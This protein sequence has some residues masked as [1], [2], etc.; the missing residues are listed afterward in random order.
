MSKIGIMILGHGSSYEY[1]K[2]IMY[3]Q[4]ER[5]EEMGFENVYIGFNQMTRPYIEDSMKAMAEDGIDEVVAV[6][7]FIASGLHMTHD[8]PPKLL[9]KEGENHVKVSVG[10]HEMLMHFEEPF[11]EDPNLA[12]ILFDKINA[13]KTEKNTAAIVIGHGSKL[14]YNKEVITLNAKRLNDMGVKTYYA[15]NELNEPKIEDVLHQMV[16]D[17]ADEIIALPLFISKGDHLKNDIP[18]KLHLKDGINEGTFV[19]NGK[20]I[21][22]KYSLPIGD[23]PRLTEVIAAKIRKYTEA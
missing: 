23:D 17:G 6:P 1:N 18:A 8:I 14:P 2:N 7:F 12:K 9:L 5:L 15:F 11:G 16:K 22:V 20:K 21:L 10:G 4:K 19:E 13:C 3:M